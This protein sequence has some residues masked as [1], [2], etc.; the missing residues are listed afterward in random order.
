MI[1]RESTALLVTHTSLH[2]FSSG[3]KM[4]NAAGSA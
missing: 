2:D 4:K 1:E 3:H